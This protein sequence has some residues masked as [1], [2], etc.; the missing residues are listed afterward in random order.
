MKITM[1]AL[2]VAGGHEVF[3]KAVGDG[4]SRGLQFF[5]VPETAP[6]A[7]IATEP[8]SVTELFR[9]QAPIPDL[10]PGAYELN[11]TRVT[12]P[13]QM[14]SNPPHHRS[15]AALYYMHVRSGPAAASAASNETANATID[16][17]LNGGESSVLQMQRML[18][19]TEKVIQQFLKYPTVPQVPLKDLQQNPFRQTAA[20]TGNENVSESEA[21]RRKEEE[22][23]QIV[24]AVQSLQ[25]QSILHSTGHNACMI[26]NTM[27]Q[28]GEQVDGFILE[29]INPNSVV[30]KSGSYRFELKMSK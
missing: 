27:Y 9:S 17:F 13:P 16:Q 14:P 3:L 6:G 29:K 18:R 2:F 5:L 28:E 21:K 26:N 22:R 20:K 12:F 1:K 30:V 7:P 23:Q 19:D 10:K 24:K 11:L 4:P 8:A 25:L 15:G